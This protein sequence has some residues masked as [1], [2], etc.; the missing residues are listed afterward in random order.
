MVRGGNEPNGP[1]NYSLAA[2]IVPFAIASVA[3]THI[4]DNGQVTITVN[5]SQFQPAALVQLV[6]GTNIY[7]AAT[8]FFGDPT[9]VKARFFFTNAV[10]GA[11][12][13]V[14]TNPGNQSTTAPQAITIETALPLTATVVPGVFNSLPRAGTTFNWVGAVA[15][16]GNIDIEYLTVVIGDDQ[17]FPI[18]LTQ[19]AAAAVADSSSGVFIVRDVPPATSLDFSFVISGFGSQGVNY[20]IV[21][22]CQSKEDFLAGV[23]DDAE[24]AR[25]FLSEPPGEV[26]LTT[27]NASGVV[28]TNIEPLPSDLTAF[29]SNTNAWATYYASILA[30]TGLLDSNDLSSLPLP[31]IAPLNTQLEN[32]ALHVNAIPLDI[33]SCLKAAQAKFDAALQA[34]LLA[35]SI[36]MHNPC[37]FECIKQRAECQQTKVE[38]EA[39]AE[40]KREKDS[41]ACPL[42]NSPPGKVPCGRPFPFPGGLPG[43]GFLPGMGIIFSVSSIIGGIA[44]ASTGASS[45]A[46]SGGVCSPSSGDPNAKE[47]PAGYGTA[48]F[49]GSQV[50]WLYTIYFENESNAP[51]FARQVSITD[52]LDP[53]LDI[54][55]FRVGN[56]IVGNTII[57][58]PTNSTYYQTRIAL[59]PP[60][61]PNI[62]ADITA[63][64]NVQNRTLSWTMNAIDLG[65]GQLVTG[66][67]E[68]V[69]PPNTTNNI[70]AG[71]VTFSIKPAADVPTGTVVTNQ[72]SIVFDINDPI[73]TDTTTNTV[74]AVPP[75]SSVA[76]LPSVINSNTFTVYWSGTDDPGGSGVASFNIYFSDNGGPKQVWQAGTTSTSAQFTGQFGHTYAFYSTAQDNSGN[77]EA[78]HATPDTTTLVSSPPVIAPV[79]D[80]TVNVGT[81]VIIT[82]TVSEA[83]QPAPA[84][85]YSLGPNAP[86]GAFVNPTNGVFIW[87]PGCDQ[88]STTNLIA[89]NVTASNN[90]LVTNS[91]LFNVVV[92]EC[93]QVGVGSTVVQTG[94][95]ATVPVNLFTTVGLTNLSFTLVYPTNRFTNW[96][97]SATNLAVATDTAQMLGPSNTFFRLTTSGGQVLQGPTE[98][99]SITFSALPGSSA[100]IPLAVTGVAGTKAD[101][102]P[103][104]NI[105]GLPGRVVVIG[106][107]P[108]LEAWLS[109]N[110]QRM[111][112]LYGN[113]GA[114]YEVD[115][116]TNLSGVNWQY[117][118]RVP[119]TNLFEAFAANG[120]LPQVFYRAFEFSANPPILQ[121]N[122]PAPS[123]LV[124]LIYGQKGT[125][126]TI[127][128]GTN[129][130]NSASWT[131][132]AGFT[133]TNS[134]QFIGVGD[135][136]NRVQFFRAKRQ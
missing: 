104:G 84:I 38:A 44:D 46:S 48:S 119:M 132:V 79:A 3:P 73:P 113:P 50:S 9:S 12:D 34:A 110:Q 21:P 91:I 40:A 82:N 17:T 87:T 45:S 25:E 10:H 52:A 133:L 118:W 24:S 28:A 23:A 75:T 62:V 15:N 107:Q 122:P 39:T 136:T 124:L 54:R 112:T 114:S 76:T 130:L 94:Q 80:Q 63:S 26:I 120:S 93:V 19:P 49:V 18:N 66:T 22:M 41:A 29:L 57:T 33:S 101:G 69:L 111:L 78:A 1:L 121:L 125:N 88:G 56:I 117:A 71:Y 126:Y 35:F 86:A 7:T 109:T 100:F 115:Y 96:T 77:V 37:G 13:V 47:G 131:S 2:N 97:I 85:A 32:L 43:R 106:P 59:P 55:T 98:A 108:L 60:N 128:S 83:D 90:P 72:A 53:N 68:G 116:S 81:G 123:N 20:Y 36:C 135:E 105:S 14:L 31:I 27:T 51:A 8:N 74:D 42:T 6:S 134:F 129:L 70:G 65:T 5:G 30:N 64:V 89:V 67:Q 127:I 11:Y 58:V 95:S 99:G 102:S 16:S 61:P 92:G 103:A 4:G